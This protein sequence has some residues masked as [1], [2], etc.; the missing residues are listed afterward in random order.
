[1]VGRKL[2]LRAD[3]LRKAFG[4]QVVLD[5]AS[6]SIYE[7]EVL[8]LRGANGSGKT[9]L[10]NILTGYLEPDAG[11]ILLYSGVRAERFEFPRK[12][13]SR[14]NLRDH[15]TPERMSENGIGRT[16][17][18]VRL[19][20]SLDLGGNLSVA[21]PHQRGENPIRSLLYRSSIVAQED[22]IA[23]ASKAA[24]NDIG[25]QGRFDSPANSIS[26]GQAKRVSVARVCQSNAKLI[27]LDEP[28]AGLDAAGVTEVMRMLRWLNQNQN[29]TFVI[30]EHVSNIP[31][32]LPFATFSL[33]LADGGVRAERI[34][35]DNRVSQEQ[36]KSS[37]KTKTCSYERENSSG[38]SL[39][40]PGGATISVEDSDVPSVPALEVE[41]LVVYRNGRLVIGL[42]GDD[43]TVRGISFKLF[44]GHHSVLRAPNGWGKTT[45][46]EALA[47]L[48]PI[49]T[50]SIKLFGEPVQD[51][52]TWERS[53][54]GFALQQ[55]RN[56]S[57]PSLT[58]RETLRLSGI[59]T[60]TTHLL[61]IIDKRMDELSGGERQ[62]VALTCTYGQ[63]GTKLM[64]L[65]EPLS[66]LDEVNSRFFEDLR[67]AVTTL[68]AVPFTSESDANEASSVPMLS[69]L[70]GPGF[71]RS[72]AINQIEGRSQNE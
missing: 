6:L 41:D 63:V 13:W 11:N 64:L 28:L 30:T 27:F 20:E 47:G 70:H 60:P 29:V 8:L 65:D 42:R 55:A 34:A 33:V 2:L 38:N 10:L 16:W 49:E 58:V 14:L 35:A 23:L 45:L 54:L 18:D 43:G 44:E 4:G 59:R 12:W 39:T 15:F 21:V 48:L 26:L 24:L 19:F 53:R 1:M 7:G 56:N 68:T 31:H 37:G 50:G 36:S 67:S 40:L 5:G 22:E 32:I 51:L 62:S 52:T 57:F 25:L 69:W 72:E 9:T 61:E 66:A 3:G 46:L 71:T 17:Q